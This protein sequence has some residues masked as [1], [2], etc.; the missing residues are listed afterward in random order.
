MTRA[1]VSDDDQRARKA[2]RRLLRS[3]EDEMQRPLDGRAGGDPDH[4]A[5][6]HQRGIERNRDVACRR[7]L[8]EM[9]GDQ[10]RVAVGERSRKRADRKALV[11]RHRDRTIPARTRRR[12]KPAAAPRPRQAARP[13]FLARAL[14]AASGGPAS[15]L[16]SR[17]SARR[18]VY[19]QSSTRRCGRPSARKHV[20]GRRALRS[21]IASPPGSRLA[22]A[23]R[24]APA[25]SRPRS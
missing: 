9:R 18:S 21:A 20:E 3:D 4:G 12:R 13:A 11:R 6:A 19:F 16:A 25:P 10:L 14:A 23:R 1:P 17:I 22:P 24:S 7:K 5:V 15:G 8:A 2:R